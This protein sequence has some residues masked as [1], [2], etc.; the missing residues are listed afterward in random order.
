MAL[1]TLA[2]R[3]NRLLSAVM[4]DGSVSAVAIDAAF[5]ERFILPAGFGDLLI[6]L[7][8]ASVA[9][10]S[11]AYV[12]P[13]PA[14]DGVKFAI[15][16][17]NAADNVDVVG[18][19]RYVLGSQVTTTPQL[20]AVYELFRNTVLRQGEQIQ[21]NSPALAGSGVTATVRLRIRGVRIKAN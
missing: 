10:F 2:I 9:S 3:S 16:D 6:E 17:Q 4:L 5:S 20:F 1:T 18:A 14:Y 7:I 21:V 8:E 15:L 19:Q 13:A 11:G 12:A